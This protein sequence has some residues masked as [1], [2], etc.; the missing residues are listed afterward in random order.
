MEIR[1]LERVAAI[2]ADWR[3]APL[4]MRGRAL[5]AH[6]EKL[7]LKPGDMREQDLRPLRDAGLDDAGILDLAQVVADF[8]YINRVADGLHVDLEVFMIPTSP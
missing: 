5:C 7:T 1:D 3:A 8:N 4:D 6:A 2:Q